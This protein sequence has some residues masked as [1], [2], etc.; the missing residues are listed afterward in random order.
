MKRERD[1]EDE[2]DKDEQEQR[3]EEKRKGKQRRVQPQQDVYP[4]EAEFI[5]SLRQ[6]FD[7][8]IDMEEFHRNQEAE[9]LLKR[10]AEEQAITVDLLRNI[11]FEQDIREIGGLRL[12][13][14]EPDEVPWTG[15]PDPS[16][17]RLSP[18]PHH[19]VD[20]NT[21]A[22][23]DL[24]TLTSD[25]PHPVMVEYMKSLNARAV[26]LLH[27][28]MAYTPLGRGF[29]YWG[30][31]S[32]QD[33]NGLPHNVNMFFS[34]KPL[35]YASRMYHTLFLVGNGVPGNFILD[36]YR[37]RGR[38]TDDSAERDVKG[39]ILRYQQH[40]LPPYYRY[41]DVQK[42]LFVYVYT[43][44]V[45]PSREDHKELFGIAAP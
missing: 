16:S 31:R 17:E 35:K 1:S 2:E 40:K 25:F 28:M 11:D 3:R 32:S 42:R 10:K 12:N 20:T 33:A 13:I 21:Q 6:G 26:K 18:P 44:A 30:N 38:L 23:L 4:T 43:D 41:F 8:E 7:F 19:L 9:N 36:W 29:E 5:H 45:V 15:L 39:L 24:L 14:K 22:E 27:W 37:T 34:K